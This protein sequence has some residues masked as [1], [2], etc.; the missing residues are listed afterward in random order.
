MNLA[1]SRRAKATC[2]LLDGQ[3]RGLDSANARVFGAIKNVRS[4]AT[5]D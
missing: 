4:P 1:D 3:N 2:V 5:T